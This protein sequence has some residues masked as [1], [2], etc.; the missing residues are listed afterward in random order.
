MPLA[1]VAVP[2]FAGPVYIGA[3]V[4]IGALIFMGALVF[5]GAPAGGL[6]LATG[7]IVLGPLA[8]DG[9]GREFELLWQPARTRLVS[10]TADTVRT[11]ILPIM[12]V[13]PDLD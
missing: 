12:I 3:L 4:F 8:M 10:S 9:V 5:S 6:L 1:V 2:R 7:F 11:G 13:S